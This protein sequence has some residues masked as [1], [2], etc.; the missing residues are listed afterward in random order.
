MLGERRRRHK[1]GL[2]SS[3]HVSFSRLTVWCVSAPSPHPHRR[4]RGARGHLAFIQL[5]VS[6]PNFK[7]I[8]MATVPMRKKRQRSAVSFTDVSKRRAALRFWEYF[9]SLWQL[10]RQNTKH[11][12]FDPSVGIT[13]RSNIWMWCMEE[14]WFVLVQL[15]GNEYVI[16]VFQSVIWWKNL[17][18][19]G[20][21]II[22]E[23]DDT[24][25]ELRSSISCSENK[26]RIKLGRDRS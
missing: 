24:R 6:Q 26:K 11:F 22:Q 4:P 14:D 13:P 21:D 15:D 17:V 9:P 20:K 19:T 16:C 7:P 12:W 5:S 2:S 3:F 8:A 23:T 1:R 18:P 25:A 10:F